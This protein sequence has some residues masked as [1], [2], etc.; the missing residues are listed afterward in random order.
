MRKLKPVKKLDQYGC[1]L[2]CIAMITGKSYFDIR[3]A[4]H[5]HM[6]RLQNVW[7]NF[8]MIGLYGNEMIGFLKSQFGITS[9]FVKFASLNTL[10]KHCILLV[11]KLDGDRTHGHG[12]VFD[13][14]SRSILD[15]D[16]QISHLK[17]Y[18]VFC[19]LEIQ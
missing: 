7:V 13:A 5:K 1:S 3:D 16:C 4:A 14:K 11:C 19:C 10:K 17:N 15:P 6:P 12:V 8:N 9:R 2:A 18:N